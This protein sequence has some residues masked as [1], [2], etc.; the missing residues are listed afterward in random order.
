MLSIGASG[1]SDSQRYTPREQEQEVRM[2][3]A[4]RD[5]FRTSQ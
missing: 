2:I 3:F 1:W 5:E 4:L